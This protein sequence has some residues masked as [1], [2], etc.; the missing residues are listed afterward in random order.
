[1]AAHRRRMG[2]SSRAQ[3]NAHSEMIHNSAILMAGL[4]EVSRIGEMILNP[5][6]GA[7][8]KSVVFTWD[9]PMT[10]DLPIDF[11]LQDFCA[12]CRKCAREC[13]CDAIPKGSKIMF[14]G[15]E[16]WQ[17][18]VE[19]CTKYPVNNPR[20]SACGRCMNMCPWNREDTA[21]NEMVTSRAITDPTARAEIT[22]QDDIAEHGK[23]NPL[24]KWWCDLEIVDGV[25]VALV[26]GVNQRGLDLM[27]DISGDKQKFA[28]YPTHLQ[29]P[30]GSKMA[31]VFPPDRPTAV[32]VYAAAP[33]MPD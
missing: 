28:M 3:S 21:E 20:G 7:R 29:P 8:S 25:C 2:D 12:G 24:K 19:K 5:F 27:A 15:Y 17:A 31:E 4:G 16:I 13:P 1:M 32:A 11:D 6:I 30:A 14:N 23:R 10:V 9:V 18:D 33:K 22:S 26:A